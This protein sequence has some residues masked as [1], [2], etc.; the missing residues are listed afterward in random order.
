M[1]TDQEPAE[2]SPQP[3]QPVS[4]EMMALARRFLMRT[5]Q[6]PPLPPP[7]PHQQEHMDRVAA[8]TAQQNAF[9]RMTG[10]A[11][12]LTQNRDP[13]V[14]D[15]Q[16]QAGMMEDLDAA[17]GARRPYSVLRFVEESP[18]S[19]FGRCM[20]QHFKLLEKMAES[21]EQLGVLANE[22]DEVKV[23]N[24]S[25]KAEDIIMNEIPSTG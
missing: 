18:E 21:A 2:G 3:A 12:P 19:K 7:T 17:L 5:P 25:K 8:V 4:S 16:D 20:E 6:D 9:N 14:R 13:M 15:V 23:N 1:P 22:L 24:T 10:Y 11:R